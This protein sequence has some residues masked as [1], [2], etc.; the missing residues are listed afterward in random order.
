MFNIILTAVVTFVISGI[1][2]ILLERWLNKARLSI[3]INDILFGYSIQ[4]FE[5]GENLLGLLQSIPWGVG[6][7]ERF[8]NTY[9]TQDISNSY[10]VVQNTISKLKEAVS[11]CEQWMEMH[12]HEPKKKKRTPDLYMNDVKSHPFFKYDI[13]GNSLTGDI[14]RSAIGS[15]PKSLGS[16]RNEKIEEDSRMFDLY[17]E[18]VVDIERID[19]Q[20]NEIV[21]D[22]GLRNHVR[23][24]DDNAISDLV[25][26]ASGFTHIFER[27]KIKTEEQRCICTLLAE[28]F[29]MCIDE[30]IFHYTK[31]FIDHSNNEIGRLEQ[32]AEGL[33]RVIENQL[34][35]YIEL[36]VYNFGQTA[37]AIDSYMGLKIFNR[38]KGDHMLVFKI[39]SIKSSQLSSSDSEDQS[40]QNRYITINPRSS[41]K[42]T[43]E[44]DNSVSMDEIKELREIHSTGLLT[45]RLLVMTNDRRKVVT[46]V[47]NFGKKKDGE[48]H[49]DLKKDLLH[50]RC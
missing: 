3:A 31:E 37:T 35:I 40:V 29:S 27:S 44:L 41:H 49:D 39:I 17:Q 28:S 21:I 34:S 50:L 2:G 16:I 25:L 32:L 1:G 42:I 7:Q 30:N 13:I 43:L 47:V 19:R 26:S 11:A 10:S 4:D 8:R 48:L 20:K 22:S 24:I 46:K 15:P 38:V 14:A 12:H 36:S 33:S 5:I 45:C 18:E 9:S 6:L 23:R